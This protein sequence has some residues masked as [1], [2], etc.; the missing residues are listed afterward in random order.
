MC[1]DVTKSYLERQTKKNG[2]DRKPVAIWHCC[3]HDG[4]NGKKFIPC[5]DI[6]CTVKVF[7]YTNISLKCQKGFVDPH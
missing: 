7:E 2:R 5:T 3:G 6:S 1:V 4:M